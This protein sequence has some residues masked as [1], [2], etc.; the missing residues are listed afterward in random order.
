MVVPAVVV[1]TFHF[2]SRLDMVQSDV[3]DMTT[4]SAQMEIEHVVECLASYRP[5][6]VVLE[7]PAADRVEIN[8]RYRAYLAGQRLLDGGEREQV[9]FR[10][11]GR[12]GHPT[13]YPV[14]ILHR[15]STRQPGRGMRRK[16]RTRKSLWAL[17]PQNDRASMA[18]EGSGSSRKRSA[19]CSMWL[20]LPQSRADAAP[21]LS[22]E[23]QARREDQSVIQRGSA[24][25]HTFT[26]ASRENA[27]LI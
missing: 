1:G 26:V 23:R 4:P 14:D 7:L 16:D 25:G 12:P 17:A 24:V 11:A 15:K 13:V 18:E 5:T 22:L 10:L 21:V 2:V 3:V 8:S 9:G 19:M 6:K 20:R 27:V